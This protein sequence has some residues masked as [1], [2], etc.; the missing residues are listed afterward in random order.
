[1]PF[2]VLHRG[3]AHH[4]KFLGK[5]QRKVLGRHIHQDGVLRHVEFRLA[6]SHVL[7]RGIV[8]RINLEAG[9]DGPH[10][11]HAGV[12]E[13]VVLYLHAKV[14]IVYLIRRIGAVIFCSLL[15]KRIH[16]VAPHDTAADFVH[17][18]VHH[19]LGSR[20]VQ[21]GGHRLLHGIVVGLRVR[22]VVCR[23]VRLR[24][25]GGTGHLAQGPLEA[26]QVNRNRV[27]NLRD[28]RRKGNLR[29]EPGEGFALPAFGHFDLCLFGLNLRVVRL[30]HF[31]GFLQRK[32]GC[33]GGNAQGSDIDQTLSHIM[34][35]TYLNKQWQLRP[36][37]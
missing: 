11:G 8:C 25:C 3:F 4:R 30:R 10:H 37:Y 36:S 17:P 12:E 2:Q 32:R 24:I 18:L 33:H 9:K 34:K 23:K 28:T 6:G 35:N 20:L 16:L 13:H 7:F 5:A 26:A 27:V 31:Q 29:Q 14:G 19:A 15:G 22:H 1:M 21:P